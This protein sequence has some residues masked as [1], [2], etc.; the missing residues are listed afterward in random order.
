MGRTSGREEPRGAGSGRLLTLEFSGR[1]RRQFQI[2]DSDLSHV[3]SQ[4]TPPAWLS[5]RW[6][7]RADEGVEDLDHSASTLSDVK[8]A[9]PQRATTF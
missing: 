3:S 5:S 6:K 1:E 9:I 2:R 7:V 8:R 4:V